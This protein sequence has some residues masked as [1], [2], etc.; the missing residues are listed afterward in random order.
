M[1]AM[2]LF[3]ICVSIKTIWFQLNEIIPNYMMSYIYIY[4]YIL[5]T[6]TYVYMYVCIYLCVFNMVLITGP[7]GPTSWTGHQSGL[8]K[9]PKIGKNQLKTFLLL[10]LFK[11][12]LFTFKYTHPIL[13]KAQEYLCLVIFEKPMIQVYGKTILSMEFKSIIKA[14]DSNPWQFTHP[15][16]NSHW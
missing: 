9:I 10:I 7:N 15:K 2:Y 1:C 6:H 3:V 14:R 11:Y 4:I 8:E 16:P 12:H 13:F 5:Y